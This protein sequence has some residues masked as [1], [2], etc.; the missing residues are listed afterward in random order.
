MIRLTDPFWPHPG[1][2]CTDPTN[3]RAPVKMSQ[4]LAGIDR[5]SSETLSSVRTQ[6]LIN[7][8]NKAPFVAE[9]LCLVTTQIR[10]KLQQLMDSVWITHAML[11]EQGN[12]ALLP[13]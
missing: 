4:A 10:S 6:N 8:L 12:A 2:S 3:R 5:G 11:A 9:R 13:W 1:Y 7:N